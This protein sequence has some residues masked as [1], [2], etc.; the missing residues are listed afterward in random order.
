MKVVDFQVTIRVGFSPG[1]ITII[2]CVNTAGWSLTLEVRGFK[3]CSL[4]GSIIEAV[5]IYCLKL[6][7]GSLD[8]Q[9]IL[10]SVCGLR[11]VCTQGAMHND[12]GLS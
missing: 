4:V 5:S 9:H 11:Y 10:R 1:S 6:C 12:S 2:S 8:A 7:A 3:S